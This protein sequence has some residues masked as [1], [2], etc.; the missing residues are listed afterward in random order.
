MI[1]SRVGGDEVRDE[2]AFRFVVTYRARRRIV[3]CRRG[4]IR[5]IRN[6]D[7]PRPLTRPFRAIVV[8]EYVSAMERELFV[9][10][11]WEGSGFDVVG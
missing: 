3:E 11:L 7:I 1:G 4:Y 5:R 2:S 10:D 8:G 9:C 6:Q